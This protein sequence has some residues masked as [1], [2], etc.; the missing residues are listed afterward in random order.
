MNSK[1]SFKVVLISFCGVL[2]FLGCVDD[3]LVKK[4][5]DLGQVTDIEGNNYQTVKIGDQWWMKEDLMVKKI[6][7]R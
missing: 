6:K 4:K 7:Y 1:I 5:Y 3:H 2:C